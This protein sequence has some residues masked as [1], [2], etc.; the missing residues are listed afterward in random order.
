[1]PIQRAVFLPVMPGGS[2]ISSKSGCIGLTSPISELPTIRRVKTVS[3]TQ[4]DVI[5]GA[6]I[7]NLLRDPQTPKEVFHT[8]AAPLRAILELEQFLFHPV[9]SPRSKEMCQVIFV[10]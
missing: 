5:K 7:T 8:R 2:K 3:G 1:M 10:C 6:L 9:I 4:E